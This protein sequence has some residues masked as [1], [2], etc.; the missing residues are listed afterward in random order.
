MLGVN[1]L[2]HVMAIYK[3]TEIC[4]FSCFQK[5]IQRTRNIHVMQRFIQSMNDMID[6]FTTI[7]KRFFISTISQ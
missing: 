2:R 3:L 1:Q 5:F 4:K 6:A 7:E